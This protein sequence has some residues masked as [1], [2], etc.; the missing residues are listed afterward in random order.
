VLRQRDGYV[1]LNNDISFITVTF[2][3]SLTKGTLRTIL[4]DARIDRDDFAMFT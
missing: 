1:I 2:I 4:N 3:R